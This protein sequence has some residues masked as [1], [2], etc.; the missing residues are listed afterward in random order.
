MATNRSTSSLRELSKNRRRTWILRAKQASS[1]YSVWLSKAAPSSPQLQQ[2]AAPPQSRISGLPGPKTSRS[3]VPWS[4][5]ATS[6]DNTRY[7]RA[8][9]AEK[10]PP[11]KLLYDRWRKGKTI[12]PPDRGRPYQAPNEGDTRTRRFGKGKSRTQL[13]S[14]LIG[15]TLDEGEP[16][17]HNKACSLGT[18]RSSYKSRTR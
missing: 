16:K 15:T 5:R 13:W 3:Y 14:S 8:G 7:S 11:L 18:Q 12:P 17:K 2:R 6:G 9:T 1:R 10:L 4:I